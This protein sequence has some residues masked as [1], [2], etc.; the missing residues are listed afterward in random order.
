MKLYTQDRRELMTVNEIQPQRGGLMIRAK[1]FGAMPLNAILTP[2]AAR[3]GLKLLGW[4]GVLY[5]L[6]LPLR[7]S[8]TG[9]EP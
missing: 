3:A 4:R 5:L 1:V 2:Q 8:R 6:T 7:R 9:D